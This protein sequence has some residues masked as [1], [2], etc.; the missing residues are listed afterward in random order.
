MPRTKRSADACR[1]L[2]IWLWFSSNS[3]AHNICSVVCTR[4]ARCCARTSSNALR[5]T[6]WRTSPCGGGSSSTRAGRRAR[7][8]NAGTSGGWPRRSH[9]GRP[10]RRP[11]TR[12]R[13]CPASGGRTGSVARVKAASRSRFDPVKSREMVS[14]ETT[15]APRSAK[16]WRKASSRGGRPGVTPAGW[17]RCPRAAGHGQPFDGVGQV[18]R[19]GANAVERARPSAAVAPRGQNRNPTT[20]LTP[21]P[22]AT[23]SIL[24]SPTF[25]PMG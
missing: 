23:S 18:G 11:R 21:Q 17:P 8:R 3:S 24:V 1:S 12:P 13:V 14:T 22:M 2:C 19:A 4:S 20:M 5:R 10:R 15:F 9:A 6:S 7:R 25:Q 16:N